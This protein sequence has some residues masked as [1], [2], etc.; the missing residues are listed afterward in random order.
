MNNPDHPEWGSWAGRYGRNENFPSF[1]YYWANQQ[2][3]W[4]GATNRDNTLARW[5]EALQNDFRARLDWCVKPPDHPPAVALADYPR[6]IRAGSILELD[7]SR[8]KDP[9]D[10]TLTFTWFPYLEAGTFRAA[11]NKPAPSNPKLKLEIPASALGVLH[12]AVSVTD[13][14]N[15]RL[16]RY[17]R[18]IITVSR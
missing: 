5:A 9:D 7:A 15:P 3:G 10:D 11:L 12:L 14:G 16:T 18:A 4:D 8:S 1:N 6:E 13:D 17:K 2:D